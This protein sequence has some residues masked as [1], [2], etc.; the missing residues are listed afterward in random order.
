MTRPLPLCTAAVSPLV[1]SAV[2]CTALPTLLSAQEQR[3]L[4]L[5]D[6]G[7]WNRITE[8]ALSAD[9]RWLSY[10]H[11]PNE[12]DATLFVREFDGT[13]SYE[14]VNGSEV[15]FSG[16]GRWAAFLASPP[17]EEADEPSEER[18]PVA[19]TLHVIDL[20]TGDR[21]ADVGVR[22]FAFSDDG[23]FLAL[24]KDRRDREAEHTGSDLL[25]RDLE[26]GTSLSFGNVAEYAFHE[27]RSY[28][29]Y[30]VD[31]DGTAGN[32]LYVVEAPTGRIR[33]LATGDDRF[34]DL[35]WS[36]VD[37]RLTALRGS[38]EDGD[39]HRT[40][41]L[42]VATGL[43]AERPAVVT[44]DPSEDADFPSGFVLSEQAG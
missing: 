36:E 25:L 6:Y 7:A 28:L 35:S 1:L 9:G 31:A 39:V 22:S 5:E 42:I 11:S 33:P 21:T 29:A 38:T 15:A 32:G 27:E 17:E 12:G 43:D 41:R 24:H 8:V 23:R 13:A 18:A 19:R 30:V 16:D 40:N 37:L 34:E 20:R 10:A 4:R 14:T 2:L 44:Y 3:P 26:A